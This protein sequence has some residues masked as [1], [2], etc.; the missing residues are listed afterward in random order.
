MTSATCTTNIQSLKSEQCFFKPVGGIIENIRD[1][2]QNKHKCYFV[3]LSFHWY[4]YTNIHIY[5]YWA[6]LDNVLMWTVVKKI[7]KYQTRE[8]EIIFDSSFC[9]ISYSH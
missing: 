6:V 7:E 8:L 1:L 2:T 9:L 3:K 4:V 5:V